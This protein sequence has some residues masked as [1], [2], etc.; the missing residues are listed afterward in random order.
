MFL[1]KFCGMGVRAMAENGKLDAAAV[2]SVPGYVL[3]YTD[4]KAPSIFAI[5]PFAVMYYRQSCQPPIG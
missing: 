3:M 1:V 5:D 2:A 4:S